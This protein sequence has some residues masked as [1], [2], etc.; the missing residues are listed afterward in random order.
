MIDFSK[1]AVYS[2]L[3]FG[4]MLGFGTQG[5]AQA[6]LSKK[7]ETDVYLFCDFKFEDVKFYEFRNDG[8]Q[9]IIETG[10]TKLVFP[11]DKFKGEKVFRINGIYY[12]Y[13]G[14]LSLNS[15]KQILAPTVLGMAYVKKDDLVCFNLQELYF[16]QK[17]VRK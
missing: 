17:G 14:F 7:F 2:I 15:E 3:C 5:F 9:E 1:K 13:G 4:V 10:F 6:P 8:L 11:W 16:F 12:V